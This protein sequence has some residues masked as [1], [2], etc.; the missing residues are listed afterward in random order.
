MD[1]QS[2]AAPFPIPQTGQQLAPAQCA[3]EM[4]QVLAMSEAWWFQLDTLVEHWI[5]LT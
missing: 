4:G 3:P 2:K 5:V 1:L